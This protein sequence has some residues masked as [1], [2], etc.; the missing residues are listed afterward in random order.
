MHIP[1][2]LEYIHVVYIVNYF[3]VQVSFLK[4]TF[5][6][7]LYKYL[8]IRDCKYLLDQIAPLILSISTI[9]RPHW[10]TVLLCIKN[11]HTR[12]IKKFIQKE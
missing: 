7:F 4:L 10:L 6:D 11:L 12:I 8:E 1:H 3:I 9:S 5:M 2:W